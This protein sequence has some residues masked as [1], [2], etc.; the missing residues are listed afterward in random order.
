MSEIIDLE[1]LEKKAFMSYHQ[2][3]LLDILLS[4]VPLCM[5]ISALTGNY[6]FII[7]IGIIALPWKSVK[8]AITVPRL[9]F[10][11]FSKERKSK[12][13]KKILMLNLALTL[14]AVA[15]LLVFMA[16]QSNGLIRKGAI[17]LGLTPLG[18][19]LASLVLVLAWLTGLKRMYAYSLLILVTFIICQLLDIYQG[20]ALVLSGSIILISGIF[21][22]I[23]FIRKYPLRINQV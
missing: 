15:G 21:I 3:G 19:T 16:W 1:K 5:G 2:D 9:G 7:L 10:V 17:S 13:K 4:I 18:V 6:L 12:E 11:E 23:L 22:L 20:F 8:K 14:S